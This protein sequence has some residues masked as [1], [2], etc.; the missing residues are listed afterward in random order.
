MD[1]SHPEN[2]NTRRFDS[3]IVAG[4]AIGSKLLTV[5]GSA[6]TQSHRHQFGDVVEN[7][8]HRTVFSEVALSG[9]HNKHTWVV[10]P[11]ISIRRVPL[12]ECRA[13]RLH[14][15]HARHFRARRIRTDFARDDVGQRTDGSP[16]SI[17]ILL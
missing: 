13:I 1:A 2:L 6:M 7:D 12:S 15:F 16:Q 10:G 3:G 5:R 17:W 9:Y 8:T 4:L 14:L 11:A